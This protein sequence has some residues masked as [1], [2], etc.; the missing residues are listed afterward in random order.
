MFNLPERFDFFL[1]DNEQC[2]EGYLDQQP[3]VIGNEFTVREYDKKIIVLYTGENLA[4]YQGPCFIP[5]TWTE[6]EQG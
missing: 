1:P 3:R 4:D 5:N 2:S 6:F